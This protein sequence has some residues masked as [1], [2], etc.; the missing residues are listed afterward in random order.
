MSPF[1]QSQPKSRQLQRAGQPASEQSDTES[2]HGHQRSQT[3]AGS[4]CW[5]ID[6][7]LSSPILPVFARR[8]RSTFGF[9]CKEDWGVQP[10]SQ[11]NWRATVDHA[12][13][14]RGQRSTADTGGGAD[15]KEPLPTQLLIMM[16]CVPVAN[17]DGESCANCGKHG[18]DIVELKGCTACRLVKYCGVDCQRAHRKQHKKAC[19]QRVAELKDEQL[20]SQ[21]HERPEGDFCPICTL[22]IP[23]P[24]GEHSA[25]M[26]CCMKRICKGCDY[27]AQKRG[28]FDCAF[29]R[30]PIPDNDADT[31]AMIQAR[32][33]KRDHE[34]INYLGQRYFFGQLGL[35]KDARKAF[36]LWAEAAELGSIQALFNL[37]VVYDTGNGVKQDES[38]GAKL[39]KKAAM[40]GCAES[41]YSLGCIEGEKGNYDRAGRHFLISSKMGHRDSVETIKRMLME[42]AA[43]KDH[44]TQALKGYQF[45]VEETKSHDRDEAKRLR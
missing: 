39:Y 2:A 17:N 26:A 20:Y 8:V 27:A 34:A 13:T 40:Q 15:H 35:Q 4:E 1:S 30:T 38:K 36:E 23:F 12:R 44:F 41:R 33:A 21:G 10:Y 29:C 18:S 11:L 25:F 42:G 31:L 45:A 14:D 24:M 9:S 16:S 3:A 43:T 28:M 32:V 19:K 5:K 37:G 7:H 22:P 6:E